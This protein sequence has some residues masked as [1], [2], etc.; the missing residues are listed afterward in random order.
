MAEDVVKLSGSLE[1][2][3]DNRGG[4]VLID[5]AVIGIVKDNIDPTHSGRIK[6]YISRYGG[7]N[8]DDSGGW[9]TV[10]YLSPFAGTI[11]PKY[12]SY[13][14]APRD[15][16]GNFVSNTHS[17]GFWASAPD[18]GS[19]V[20][21]IFV[22]GDPQDGYYMGCVPQT[23]LT[24]MIPAIAGATKVVPNEGEAELYAGANRLPVT[25][26]NYSNPELR[27]SS[28]FY[29]EPKPVHS[30]QANILARQGLIRDDVRGVI[31]SSS[32]RE[33]PSR[34]FGWSTPGQA[35]YEGGYTNSTIKQAAATADDSGLQIIG[36]TGGH[37]I[38]MD[39]GTIDGQDQLVRFRTT[40]GHMIM[41]H[42]SGQVIT[43]I[44]S[45]GQSYIELGKEGTIDLYSTNSVNIRTEG[46][47]NL[48]ADR[49]IN[50]NAGRNLNM[51]GQSANLQTVQDY[52]IRTGGN[53]YNYVA[54]K[55]TLNVDQQMSL[56]SAGNSSFL[57]SA[58][59][60]ING[61]KIH[62]NTGTS[63]VVPA[64]VP[65]LPKVNHIDT[66][67]SQAKGWMNPAPNPIKS[68]TSRAPAHM[69]WAAANKGVAL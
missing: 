46:D 18:I 44:H 3:R 53:Y 38:V 58:I 51:C 45:N 8:P 37:S 55:Y 1:E 41:L 17:Y 59:N 62:L 54:G 7:P 69:P 60:Y 66:T 63:S 57:S 49:D 26:I 31:S 21:C 28:I 64:V 39:D 30:Y 65:E 19:Q 50:I 25:E 16:W 56:H 47:L 20:I 9:L 40:A 12:S 24:H 5:H 43:I 27:N 4:A 22:N 61:K 10:K 11:S 34:V 48:H 6:V 15:N 36:R 13:D 29:S 14:G 42:D 52:R 23:G 67:F 33:T 68:I 35:I 2:Y 32:Q